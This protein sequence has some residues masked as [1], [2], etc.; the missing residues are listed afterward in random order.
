MQLFRPQRVDGRDL[1]TAAG[2]DARR[3]GRYSEQDDG[4]GRDGPW[5]SG[6]MPNSRRSI[7]RVSRPV[8]TTPTTD[9]P[10][11]AAPG[12]ASNGSDACRADLPARPANAFC[13]FAKKNAEL[14]VREREP[15][16]QRR[17][18]ARRRGGVAPPRAGAAMT[19]TPL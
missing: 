18:S 19:R 7:R 6:A 10:S 8:A 3:D 5:S 17:R 15:R 1:R 11:E 16:H 9:S 13:T 4:R 14:W 2:R 12:L